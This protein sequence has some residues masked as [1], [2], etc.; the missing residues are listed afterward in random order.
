MIWTQRHENHV[1]AEG[2]T[3]VKLPPS[4]EHLQ[5]KIISDFWPAEL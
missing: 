5:R 2:K 1:K 4:K 3:Q